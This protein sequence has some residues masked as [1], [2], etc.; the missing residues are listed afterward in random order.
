MKICRLCE[1][2]KP[3]SE[4][5]KHPTGKFGVKSKCKSCYNAAQ[6]EYYSENKEARTAYQRKWNKAHPEHFRN[7]KAQ[8]RSR[9]RVSRLSKEDRRHIQ[10]LYRLAKLY[11]WITGEPWH[12]DHIVPLNGSN[13]CGL[14]LPSN[15][16]VVPA[17]YNLK[18]GA[19]F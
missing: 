1:V 3:L 7:K 11:G 4:F 2:E 8:R 13:V 17:K 14:H 15:L 16:Q 9:E 12:V 18:K 10:G 5:Y 19:S 6:K